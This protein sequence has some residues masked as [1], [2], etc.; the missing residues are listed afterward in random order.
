MYLICT[1]DC[2]ALGSGIPRIHSSETFLQAFKLNAQV[3]R[4]VESQ[5]ASHIGGR[6]GVSIREAQDYYRTLQVDPDAEPEVII[7]AYRKL[8]GKYHPDLNSSPDAVGRMQEI[9]AAYAILGDP[10]QRAAYD[11]ARGHGT[12]WGRGVPPSQAVNVPTGA[13]GAFQGMTRAILMMVAS[14]LIVTLIFQAFAGTGGRYMAGAVI[15]GLLL[16]K[17]G[18]ILRYFRGQG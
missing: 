7:A 8:A 17:G 4:G 5:P 13:R 12:T 1:P 16:W 9:N 6:V 3:I 15:L 14:S 10:A 2:P 18:P 11:H